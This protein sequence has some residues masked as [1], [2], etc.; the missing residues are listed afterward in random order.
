MRSTL[1][2]YAALLPWQDTGFQTSP[3]LKEFLATFGVPITY[4]Q[5]VPD[6]HYPASI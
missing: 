2:T 1:R 3:I 5:M 4:L 6:M